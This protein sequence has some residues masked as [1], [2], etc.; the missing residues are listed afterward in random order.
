MLIL[1]DLQ[2]ADT[3]SLLLLQFLANNLRQ[4]PLFIIGT[5]RDGEVGRDHPLSKAL[6]EL[7]RLRRVRLITL[8]GLGERDVADFIQATTGQTPITTLV[9]LM[10]VLA[11]TMP[12]LFGRWLIC[13]KGQSILPPGC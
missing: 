4:T 5:Y 2:R 11:S 9:T 12:P 10:S 1:D 8:H 3:P 7:S 6:A 13:N